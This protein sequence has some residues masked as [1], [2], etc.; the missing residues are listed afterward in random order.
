MTSG[1]LG[2][3][4]MTYGSPADDLHDIGDYLAAV[5]GGRPAPDELVEEFRRRYELIGGSPLIPITRDQAAA[6]EE[7]L[8]H[9][10]IDAVGTIG[11]RFSAPSILDGLRELA[12]AGCEEVSA[13]VMSPQYSELLMAGYRR[14]ID[15]AVAE[16]GPDAPTVHLAPAWH[17]EAGFVEAV[18]ERIRTGLATLP[19]GAP[20]LLTAHSLPKR[21]AEAEPAY[22]DQLRETA[23]AVARAAG[24]P[25]ERWTFCWQSAGHEPGEWMKPDFTDVLPRLRDEGHRAVLVAPIQFLADHLEILYDVDIG[26]R[27][28]ATEAGMAFARIESLNLSPTFI[29]A[30][31]SVARGAIE[32]PVRS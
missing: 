16:L 28:Q 25:E 27:E 8:R 10:G 4:L 14:A 24:V 32:Q 12:D 17:R 6:V 3:L 18:A 30:L 22:L 1:R 29:G 13:I 11:M 21:V 19:D 7:R 26:A 31:A 23:E 15:G 2:V 9:D 20:V 5:R